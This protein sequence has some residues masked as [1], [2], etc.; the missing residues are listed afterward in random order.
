ME[1]LKTKPLSRPVSV[2]AVRWKGWGLWR[3]GFKEMVSFEFRVEK[4]RSDGQWK[5]WWWDRRA[6]KIQLR[7]VRK[8]MIRIRLTE[9]GRKFI[10][11]A[12]RCITK[13]VIFKEEDDDGRERVTEEEELVSIWGESTEIKFRRYPGWAMSSSKNFLRKR[14]NFI[15]NTLIDFEPLV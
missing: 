14:K 1:K 11:K 4:S 10:P 12:R 8:R 9:W 5:W 2:K 15:L 13:W 7:R 3:E 6:K